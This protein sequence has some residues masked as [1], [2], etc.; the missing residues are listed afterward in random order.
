MCSAYNN[1]KLWDSAIAAGEKAVL[2]APDNKLA[3][4]N[5]AFAK[6]SKAADSR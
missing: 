3:K 4:N 5:L 2:L 1:L 6:S